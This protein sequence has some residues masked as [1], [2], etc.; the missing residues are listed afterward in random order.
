VQKDR[1]ELG[2]EP[3]AHVSGVLLQGGAVRGRGEQGAAGAPEADR[4]E[5]QGLGGRRRR[6]GGPRDLPACPGRA[7]RSG[8]AT[9]VDSRGQEAGQGQLPGAQDLHARLAGSVAEEWRGGRGGGQRHPEPVEWRDLG[10]HRQL[11][12]RHRRLQ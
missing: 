7:R 3:A 12:A 5:A 4:A 11:A 8:Q 10:A 1:A 9:R 2:R 6:Q